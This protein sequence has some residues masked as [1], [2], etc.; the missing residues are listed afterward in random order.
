M[1]RV[2]NIKPKFWDCLLMEGKGGLGG[3]IGLGAGGNDFESN[4]F[5]CENCRVK[6]RPNL[7]NFYCIFLDI[8]IYILLFPYQKYPINSASPTW[9]LLIILISAHN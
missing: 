4:L 6:V 2:R 8:L 9:H 1:L 7:I 5:I 3:A